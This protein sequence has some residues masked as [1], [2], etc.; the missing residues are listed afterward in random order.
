MDS[1]AMG[2]PDA[3]HEPVSY[4]DLLYEGVA[5]PSTHPEHLATLGRLAGMEPAPATNCRVLELGCG[6][7]GNIVPMAYGLPGS[8]F[9]GI[10]LSPAEI[11]YAQ[12]FAEALD[13]RNVSLRQMDIRDVGAEFGEFDYII[14]Y[15][16]Y[17]WVPRDVQAAVLRICREHLAPQGMAVISYNVYPGWHMRMGARQMMMFHSMRFPPEE[18]TQEALTLLQFVRRAVHAM[19]PLMR[20][21]ETYAAVLDQEANRL[22]GKPHSYLAHEHLSRANEPVYFYQFVER[23]A[24]A[25]LG[26]A[27]DSDFGSR[28]ADSM[29]DDVAGPIAALSPDL[30]TEEQYNDFVTNRMF[31]ESLICHREVALASAVTGEAMRSLCVSSEAVFLED[32]AEGYDPGAPRI[33]SAGGNV[34]SLKTSETVAA[35]EHLTSIWPRA[36]RFDELLR[37]IEPRLGFAMDDATA[38]RLAGALLTLYRVK[39]VEFRSEAPRCIG[40][41][42]AG[43]RPVAFEVA[44]LEARRG[45]TVTNVRHEAVELDPPCRA[46]LPAMD[47]TH[48]RAELAAIMALALEPAADDSAGPTASALTAGVEAV[49]EQ[50]G[51]MSLLTG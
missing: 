9:T 48:T 13:V 16:V 21:S 36:E 44:R 26:Y 18:R 8:Q 33:R 23:A 20:Y 24:E 40:A 45:V 51:M 46:L 7:G 41:S 38:A 50:L 17:S 31:R 37:S 35:L 15:G 39:V 11:A 34:V 6:T 3:D 29:P 12:G 2:R 4:E 27:G 49:I 47:G 10:D 32:G 42:A 5:L 14:A 30:V 22:E 19:K 43:E 1:T 28:A 25:G